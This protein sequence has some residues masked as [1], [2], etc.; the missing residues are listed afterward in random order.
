M[1][2]EL[3]QQQVHFVT[4]VINASGEK[5]QQGV[6]QA[7][8]ASRAFT[9]QAQ[10][11]DGN[12][13]VTK[14]LDDQLFRAKLVHEHVPLTVA[15][16]Y[17]GTSPLKGKT[18]VRPH[19]GNLTLV[20]EVRLLGKKKPGR[21]QRFR[22]CIEPASP[23]LNAQHTGLTLYSRPFSTHSRVMN[24]LQQEARRKSSAPREPLEDV[25]R[26]EPPHTNAQAKRPSR[27]TTD[28]ASGARAKVRSTKKRRAAPTP[29]PSQP[30]EEDLLFPEGAIPLIPGPTSTFLAG[31]GLPMMVTGVFQGPMA[32]GMPLE[33]Y[34][35]LPFAVPPLSQARQHL[36]W[37]TLS[38]SVPV[39]APQWFPRH[40]IVSPVAGPYNDK[41]VATHM[42]PY[43]QNSCIQEAEERRRLASGA[44]LEAGRAMGEMGGITDMSPDCSQA[45]SSSGPSVPKYLSPKNPMPGRI[46]PVSSNVSSISV[47]STLIFVNRL[48]TCLTPCGEASRL[49]HMMC[50]SGTP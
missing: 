48:Q 23:V 14:Q 9:L 4:S 21:S 2:L 26:N 12:S 20:L 42:P 7:G 47:V 30:L 16:E 10:V 36:L 5:V 19:R 37:D 40:P 33:R 17:P 27:E 25:D 11:L 13:K 31:G 29:N 39:T 43:I 3:I 28:D 24:L 34:P 41:G 44:E 35:T 38:L 1:R 32:H 18:E 8:S 46:R 45:L 22:I 15:S 49:R 6:V 50:S